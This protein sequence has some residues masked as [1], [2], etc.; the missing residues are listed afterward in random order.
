[1]VRA[2]KEISYDL[3]TGEIVGLLGPNG[4]GKTTTIK[5]ISAL[6]TPTSGEVKVKGRSVLKNSKKALEKTSA[7]LEGNRNVY[8]RLTPRENLEFFASLQGINPARKRDDIRNLLSSLRLEEKIDT[9]ARKLSRGMQ[10]KLALA[11]ALVREP[12]LLLLDEPTLGLDV[13]AS[14]DMRRRVKALAEDDGITILLSSHDMDVVEEVCNRVIVLQ[15]GEIVVKDRVENLIDLFRA[16]GYSLE[17]EGELTETAKN[18]LKREFDLT[19][20]SASRD[21]RTEVEV[22]L[23]EPKEV[24]RLLERLEKGGAQVISLNRENPDLED[25]F[26]NIVEGGENER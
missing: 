26:L 21:N 13:R 10:Q 25:V 1:L 11:A 3:D 6:I 9:P 2:V 4:A 24:Y 16:E 20:N 22:S 7:V 15:E 17:V 12:E 23:A 18:S 8:W 14:R 19:L 5:C